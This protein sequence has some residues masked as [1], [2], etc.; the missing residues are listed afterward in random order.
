MDLA[1]VILIFVVAVVLIG[2]IWLLT[3][4]FRERAQ[5]LRRERERL[6]SVVAGHRDM[7]ESHASTA[8]ELAPRV[9]EHRAAAADHARRAEEL[10]ERVEKE[11]QHQE[12]HERRATETEGDRGRI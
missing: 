11:R 7:A 3:R 8:D 2:A 1:I 6:E 9:D 5:A 4:R 10:A 12:F